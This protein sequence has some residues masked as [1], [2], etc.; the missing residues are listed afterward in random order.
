MGYSNNGIY[1]H[2]TLRHIFGKHWCAPT[3][4]EPNK[5][6]IYTVSS[7]V[8]EKITFPSRIL[9]LYYGC[10]SGIGFQ[11]LPEPT[12][13]VLETKIFLLTFLKFKKILMTF[14]MAAILV[15]VETLISIPTSG[16]VRN[17]SFYH[18][19]FDYYNSLAVLMLISCNTVR[20]RENRHHF[21]DDTFKCIFV[22]DAWWIP[23]KISL[24]FVPKGPINNITAL[25]QIM[26]CRLVGAKPLSEPMMVRLPTHI[27]VTRPQ[28][29]NLDHCK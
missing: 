18:A 7:C 4:I 6:P 25:V 14:F 19:D 16:H 20:P 22:N 24:K 29:V 15:L 13:V 28:W 9:W 10:R 26:A 17:I 12:F 11:P 1:W 5:F 27:C 2:A 3:E 21:A 23:I 8:S